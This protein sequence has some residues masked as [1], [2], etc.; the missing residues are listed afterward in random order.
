MALF[1]LREFADSNG[2]TDRFGSYAVRK[3]LANELFKR[4]YVYH[5]CKQPGDIWPRG[6]YGRP[7]EFK[8]LLGD[9]SN[10]VVPGDDSPTT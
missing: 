6:Y 4:G 1:T 5:Q 10:L 7:E 3:R 2:F 9:M 8:G